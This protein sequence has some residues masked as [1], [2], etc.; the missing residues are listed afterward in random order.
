MPF[1]DALTFVRTWASRPLRTGAILPSGEALARLITSRITADTG[2]VLE[3]GP[4]TGVFTR[5]MLDKGVRPEDLTLVEA[6]PEFAELLRERFPGVRVLAMDATGLADMAP[7]TGAKAG[8][9][10]SG[11]PLLSL[12]AGSIEPILAGAFAWLRP[13]G[14]FYQFT[15]G[16]RCPVPEPIREALGLDAQRIGRVL[17]N[18]PPAS[19]WRLTRRA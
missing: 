12:P 1:S 5:A 7:P 4:G 17:R 8:A 13:D 9:V 3:L 15:Y 10:V 6:A 2:P 11:L 16:P 18:V 14:A 19:V